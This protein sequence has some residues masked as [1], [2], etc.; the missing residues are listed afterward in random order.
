MAPVQVKVCGLTRPA[1]AAAAAAAGAAFVGLVFFARS[2]RHVAPAQG[3]DVALA[4]PAGIVK[5]GLFVDPDDEMLERVL[6]EV[7]LDMLQLHGQESP[8]RV[9]AIRSR[10]GRPVMKALGI[11]TPGDLAAAAAYAR[12]ADMLLFDARPP[13]G[14]DRPGGHGRAFDWSL[15]AGRGVARPWMLAGGLTPATVARAVAESGARAVDVSSGVESAPGRKDPAAMR[16]FIAAA[17]EAGE[18]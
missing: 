11:A 5:V 17:G 15:L 18:A 14:A 2:P 12:I 10:A 16:A 1:D 3:R 7:P 4:V 6:A 9:A 13:K 8:A